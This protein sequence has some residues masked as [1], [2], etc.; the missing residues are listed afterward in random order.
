M[1]DPSEEN[2]ISQPYR[3][4]IINKPAHMV[5]QFVSP[6]NVGLLGDLAFDFPEGTHAVG[7]LDSDSEGLLILTT[8]KKVT[9]LLFLGEI[10]HKRTYW[11][12]VAHEVRPE[13]LERLRNGIHIEVKGGVQYLT[14][15]CEVEI[16]PRPEMLSKLRNEERENVSNTWL[17]I[18]LTEGKYHQVRKMVRTAGHRCRRLVRTS[19]ED[20][21]LDGLE[22]G[23]VRE[24]EEDAFFRLLKIR[25]WKSGVSSGDLALAPPV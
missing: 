12:N 25:N 10:P 13:T 5:S 2:T 7:R 11:V 14:A 22:P 15:P 18:S 19:I 6:H 16:I 17:R 9:N 3:Y 1:P 20:L 23:G 24:I 4:F 21:Q 8:N